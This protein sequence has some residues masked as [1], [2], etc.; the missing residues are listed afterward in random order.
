MSDFSVRP[1]RSGSS[2]NLTLV[3]HAGTA[4]LVD[5]GLPSQRALSAALSEAGFDWD[6][7]DAVLVSHLH[8][9]H[10]H[11]SAVACCA[12][13]DVPILIHEKN[14]RAYSRRILSRSPASG[15]LRT[16][17]GEP[18][19]VGSIEV[20]PF[21]VPHD[22]EGLTCGFRIEA[23]SG[24]R[25]ARV[26]MATDL[27]T[28][29][30]GLFE[31]FV[32][33]DI[34]LIESNYDPSMLASSHRNHVDRARV[35]SDVGHLSNEQAGKFLVRTFQESR[36]LPRAVVLCHLS[37]DH[38]TPALAVSTVRGILSRY[39]FGDVPVHAAKRNG[40]S[41]RYFAMEAGRR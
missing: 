4:F 8:G 18:F 10:I 9:D 25:E 26:S 30:N 32:D 24:D 36:K 40:P 15:P 33:S 7:I 19:A 27:G 2:G 5:A 11:P 6:D 34:I 39:G 12:R 20:H 38:N 14:V 3:E 29:G 17:G 16:F 37:A 28:G 31:R 35:D 21:A 13:H 23:R 22:A 1:L 41:P